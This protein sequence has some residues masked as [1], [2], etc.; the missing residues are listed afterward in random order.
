MKYVI[1]VRGRRSGCHSQASVGIGSLIIFIAMILVAGITAS[2]LIQTMN[3]LEQTALRTGEE[4]I[5]DISSGI[6]V[7]HVSGYN[8]NSTITQMVVFIELTGASD[9]IDLTYTYVVLSDGITKVI[10][11]YNSSHFSSSV[12]GGLFGTLSTDNM[13]ATEYGVMVVRDIDGSCQSTSAVINS[14]DLI[15]LLIN[16]SACFS[17]GISPRTEVSGSIMPEY[18]FKGSIAFSTPSTLTHTIIDLQS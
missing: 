6:K 13:S 8:S 5:R 12:S 7:T 9:A 18:G 15:V 16:T 11:H 14:D 4:T 3:S 2:V 17:G 1:I 10:L